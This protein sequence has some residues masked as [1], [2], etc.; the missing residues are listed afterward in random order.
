MRNELEQLL[1]LTQEEH[2]E[3]H[4][5]TSS[6]PFGATIQGCRPPCAENDPLDHFSGAAGP[7]PHM[8]LLRIKNE[9]AA[10][11]HCIPLN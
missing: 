1:A 6:D 11:L 10:P 3:K 8:S 4:G 5:A 7:A 2:E 9:G